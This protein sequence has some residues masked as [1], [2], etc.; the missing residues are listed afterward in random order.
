MSLKKPR[1]HGP[2]DAP[3]GP[4]YPYRFDVLRSCRGRPVFNVR[5]ALSAEEHRRTGEMAARFGLSV[6]EFLEAF[7]NH[8]LPGQLPREEKRRPK[9]CPEDFRFDLLCPELERRLERAAKSDGQSVA[10][11][12][13]AA[14]T[15]DLN[16]TE[17]V[18]IIDPATGEELACVW[19]LEGWRVSERCLV[20][21][22]NAKNPSGIVELFQRGHEL[23]KGGEA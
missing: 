23:A 12:L 17:E 11:F 9:V 16:S 8:T 4:R 2:A 7:F 21:E 6:E 1:H 13:A 3:A 20:E 18:M 15:G 14:L 5:L 19:T 10:E 22:K